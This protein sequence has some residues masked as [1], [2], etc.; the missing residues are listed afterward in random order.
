M[1]F[2]KIALAAIAPLFLLS[3]HANAQWIGQ[4]QT[5]SDWDFLLEQGYFDFGSYQLYRDLAEGASVKDTI[6][7]IQSALGNNPA[8]L[9]SPLGNADAIQSLQETSSRRGY[10]RSGQRVREGQNSGYLLLSNAYQN[11][12]VVFKGRNDNSIWQTE[13]RSISLTGD[14]YAVTVGNYNANIGLGLGIG[15]YDYRPINM[16]QRQH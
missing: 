2:Q 4:I 7:Y 3:Y 11:I 15:R 8:D 13:R 5:E 14:S 6:E 12:G 1:R 9:I 10:L 16:L